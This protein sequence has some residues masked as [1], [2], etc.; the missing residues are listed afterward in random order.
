MATFWDKIDITNIECGIFFLSIAL[1]LC[2]ETLLK[3]FNCFRRPKGYP[4]GESNEFILKIFRGIGLNLKSL[5]FELRT[6][7]YL[8]VKLAKDCFENLAN[9]RNFVIL[10][11]IGNI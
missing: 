10:N 1:F 7:T 5:F 8:N 3:V 6:K 4:P 9:V 11:I 2:F